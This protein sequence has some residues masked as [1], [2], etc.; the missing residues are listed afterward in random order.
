[1]SRDKSSVKV[2]VEEV[3]PQSS[4][5]PLSRNHADRTREIP[6]TDDHGTRMPSS[7]DSRSYFGSALRASQAAV[8]DLQRRVDED[9]F[10]PTE[11]LTPPSIRRTSFLDSGSQPKLSTSEAYPASYRNNS[12][13]S[14]PVLTMPEPVTNRFVAEEKEEYQ[15]R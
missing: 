12:V 9:V 3:D 6:L 2:T 4:T 13:V 7:S 11:T 8:D 5:P 15:L 10:S 1:M 14:L